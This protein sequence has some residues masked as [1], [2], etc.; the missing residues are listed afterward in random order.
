MTLDLWLRIISTFSTLLIGV[1]ASFLACQQFRLSKSRLKFDLY[2]KRLALFMTVRDFAS[3]YALR[4][5]GDPGKFYRD[6]IERFFLFD[7]DVT[8]YIY[9]MYEKANEVERTKLE[10]ERP[11]LPEGEEQALKKK[12]VDGLV[13]FYN[14]SD[15]MIKVFSKDM[16]IKTLR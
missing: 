7:E 14:Q 1:A 15:S 10:L 12:R 5:E 13:W 8:A 6:T 11:N 16:S 9:G 2:E 3:I 4:G